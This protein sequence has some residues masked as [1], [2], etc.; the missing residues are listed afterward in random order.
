MSTLKNLRRRYGRTSLTVTGVAL[1][2]AFTTIMLSI[3]EG[4]SKSSQ[5][6]LEETGVDLLVE[7]VEFMP[8][9]QEFIPIFEINQSREIAGSME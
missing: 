9:I 4:I 8:L 3:G 1:A 5:E 7:P 6:I 2:I